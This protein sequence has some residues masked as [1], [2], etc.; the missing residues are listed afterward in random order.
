M[1]FLFYF[2]HLD[3]HAS[4]LLMELDLEFDLDYYDKILGGMSLSLGAGASAG[5][6]TS[7]PLPHSVGAGA[8]VAIVLMYHGIFRNGPER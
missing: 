7:F 1:W 8:L 6:L 3:S 4:D 5:V 2:S